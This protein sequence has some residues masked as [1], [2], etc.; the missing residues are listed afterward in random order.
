MKCKCYILEKTIAMPFVMLMLDATMDV[1]GIEMESKIR[2]RMFKERCRGKCN[3]NLR[4][5]VLNFKV[6]KFNRKA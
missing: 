1:E 3:S 2:P 4:G 5:I 6:V